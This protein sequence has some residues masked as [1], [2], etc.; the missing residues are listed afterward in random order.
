MPPEGPDSEEGRALATAA[1]WAHDVRETR[2]AI[3]RLV[4]DGVPLA[5]LPSR[6]EGLGTRRASGPEVLAAT[7]IGTLAVSRP[8][9]GKVATRRQLAALGIDELA[10]YGDVPLEKL[11][12]LDAGP[13]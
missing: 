12:E 3:V 9:A 5:S 8:R 11:I 4:T 1:A 7:R 13:S 2:A 10:A 6:V